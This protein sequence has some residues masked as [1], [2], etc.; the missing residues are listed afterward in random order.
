MCFYIF[1]NITV[2]MK[3]FLLQHDYLHCESTFNASSILSFS[4]WGI[5]KSACRRFHSPKERLEREIKQGRSKEHRRRQRSGEGKDRLA[6]R[7]GEGRGME[8]AETH[9][10]GENAWGYLRHRGKRISK[11]ES[12][13]SPEDE[14][15][16]DAGITTKGIPCSFAGAWDETSVKI[17][18]HRENFNDVFILPDDTPTAIETGL[19]N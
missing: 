5:V 14:G 8:I 7:N 10:Y 2:K 6:W 18:R 13:V 15:L 19:R 1:I 17:K 12:E 4:T 16:A 9:I 11:A 3:L